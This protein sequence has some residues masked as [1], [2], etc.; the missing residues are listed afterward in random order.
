M[1]QSTTSSRPLLTIGLVVHN[2]ERHLDE[3]IHSFRNQTFSNFELIIYDNASTDATPEIAL[4]H[5]QADPRV[6]IVRHPK[7]IGALAN[8]VFA[9]EHA[10]TDF[11]C[12]AAHDDVR[13]P[14]F[15]KTLLELF[16]ICP[17]A[18]FTCCAARN[19]N[20]DGT[21]AETRPE[22]ASL[23]K[24]LP[25]TQINR[26]KVY[27]R[28][29]PG[30]IF[31]GVFRLA[32]L[33][34]K[35]EVLRRLDAL[36]PTG[37]VLL[38]ADMIFLAE[39]LRDFPFA[40]SS[41]PLLLF[42]R[43]GCSHNLNAYGSLRTF[44]RH[45]FTFARELRRATVMPNAPLLGRV[46]LLIARTRFL[47]NYLTSISMRRMLFH[48]LLKALPVLSCLTAIARVQCNTSFRRLRRRASELPSSTR[49]VI[50]GAGKHTDRCFL[51]IA[52]ALQPNAT[53]V[54]VCDD[55]PRNSALTLPVRV[56]HVDILKSL[57]PALI[58]ISSDTYER[59]LMLRA[60]QVAPANSSIW[61]IY[62]T[63]LE[64]DIASPTFASTEAMN[65]SN[66]RRPR[67]SLKAHVNC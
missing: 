29:A 9:A 46:V 36:S 17:E 3:A 54:A 67:E 63:Q 42:R 55:S 2:G 62:D 27:L 38:G 22:T 26:T 33:Q 31:Y 28:E 6:Q 25:Q 51:S 30:T 64:A 35:L 23:H 61:C 14:T 21:R 13:E 24:C 20:P 60:K 39:F 57:N 1:T 12:W 10:A 37:P 43:G 47:I 65:S 19:L 48:Y 52:R 34:S 8:F 41:E 4:R 44:G 58:V 59:Q 32:P 53:I 66:S 45:V 18:A 56:E 40:I 49:T 5:S 15:L 50:F 16:K 11:F 7:N